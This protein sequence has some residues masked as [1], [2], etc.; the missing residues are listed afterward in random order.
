MGRLRINLTFK[1]LI[2]TGLVL[3]ATLNVLFYILV[4]RQEVLIYNQV[5]NEARAIFKLIV[6]TRSWIADH[7]GIFVEQLPWT[8]A[9]GAYGETTDKSGRKLI[10][11]T[12]AM[13]TK[14]L[15][16]YAKGRGFYWFHITSLKLMN[17][18]NAPDD[19]ERESL[20][21]FEE[22]NTGERSKIEMIDR[23]RYFRYISPLYVESA[24]LACHSHQGYR[25]G[26]VRGAI[27][28]TI[29][30][31]EVFSQLW[32]NRI[33][34]FV[35]GFLTT[36]VM[37]AAL[38]LMMSG[39][40]LSPL[41]KLNASIKDF[42]GGVRSENGVIRTGDEIGELSRSFS[43]MAQTLTKYHTN[44]EERIRNAVKDLEETNRRLIEANEQLVDMDRK[45]SDFVAKVS[46]ELRTPLTSIKGAMDYITVRLHAILRDID[47]S[48]H[49]EHA[50]NLDD[51]LTFFGIIKKNAERLI[52]MVNDLL[53][54]ERIEQ[55]RS[56]MH[57]STVNMSALI[58]E[59]A[60]G[61]RSSAMAREINIQVE[62]GKD[63]VTIADEDRIRQVLINLVS[64]ALIYSPDRSTI[65]IN[66]GADNGCLRVT[67]TDTGPGIPPE[68]Q[69][70]IF[71]R[72]YTMGDKK[73]T[74]L[75]L[76]ISKGII[77]AHGG[78]IG[79]ESDGRSGSVF[80]FKL[81]HTTEAEHEPY[82]T[83]RR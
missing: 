26:D 13:V 57:L 56:E 76:A 43:E 5:E 77:E 58:E 3:V 51:L 33:N 55:G 21:I 39:M 29:P 32:N 68:Q 14:E 70:R 79:V 54:L 50:A 12:P 24:C 16:Q 34:M 59:V 20:R 27:S 40:I 38:Y 52:R 61:F 28:V 8:K 41:H 6:L 42:A 35:V 74:G 7:G 60:T 53:D 75:G 83:C 30:M 23:A 11:K 65:Q 18:E 44:L 67:V 82:D 63:L 37:L 45:K 78:I 36:L 9:A 31:E 66:A 10:R 62:P 48:A 73:G 72:F 25:I 81:P 2:G 47:R 1:F 80:F 71:D 64:N 22:G 49:T 15:A 4:H 46:H 69:E 19:F 17:P